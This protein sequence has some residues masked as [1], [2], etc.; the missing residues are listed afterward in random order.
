MK[1]IPKK[2][3]IM[4]LICLMIAVTCVA[5]L[6]IEIRKG[7]S[8]LQTQEVSESWNAVA[9]GKTY[10]GIVLG[11]DRFDTFNSGD[12]FELSCT[13]PETDIRDP[14]LEM[15]S[16]HS[17]VDV[18]VDGK[19]IYNYG[20]KYFDAGKMLG[21]GWNF[22]ELPDDFSG[23]ELRI[24]FTV[25]EDNAF[26]GMPAINII[27]GDGAINELLMNERLY[28]AIG[29]F[30]IVIGAMGMAFALILSFRNFAA[31]KMFCIMLFSFL[32]G[33]YTLANSDLLSV[34]NMDLS[35]KC[36]FEYISLYTFAIPFTVYFSDWVTEKGFPKRLA[37]F[38]NI[39]VL[40]EFVFAF[41][42]YILHVTNILHMPYFVTCSHI[43]MLVT[44]VLIIHLTVARIKIMGKMDKGLTIG[45]STALTVAMLEL[46]RYN[47]AKYVTGFRNNKYSSYIGI[48]ALIVFITLFID[49]MSKITGNL[50]KEA[51]A[52]AF[53]KMAYMDEL[54]G[55]PNRRGAEEEMAK[56][57]DAKGMY[58]LISVDMN[59][60]KM[61]NDTFG[62][63]TGDRALSLL[64]KKLSEAFPEPCVVARVGGDEFTVIVRNT[65]REWVEKH[66]ELFKEKMEE[67]NSRG[68]N[69]TLSAAYGVAYEDEAETP[70]KVFKIAD[71]RMYQNKTESKMG[72]Q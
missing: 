40:V 1:R 54:T 49:F 41:I 17:M 28:L 58:A 70:E 39:W 3:L 52:R 66:L 46:V 43:C 42:V 34:F 61:M 55:I 53:E 51:E 67:H 2:N 62:H 72:R 24:V 23:K 44:L 10:E 47:I 6:A 37:W 4:F 56:L 9:H 18:Y 38:Y 15:Y 57:K 48:A 16:V 30:L 45:F 27:N 33:V 50:R 64:A 7:D 31:L 5:I 19:H 29:M 26:E 25:T 69:V 13:L 60:L 68:D 71:D 14:S 22:V 20:Q 63:A 12:V 8:T 11:R 36:L 35:Q 21:Y 32:I 59:L 65:S